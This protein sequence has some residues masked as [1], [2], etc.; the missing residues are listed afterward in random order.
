MNSWKLVRLNFGSNAAHFGELGIGIEETSERVRSDTLF[1]ALITAYAQL[2]PDAVSNLLQ[3]FLE[4][5]NKPPFR[6]SSTFLYQQVAD[7]IVDYLPKPLK[8]PCNY[9]Q[10]DDLAF[11]KT[12]KK[13]NFLPVEVWHRWYQE[14]G[15]RALGVDCDCHQLIQETTNKSNGSLRKACTFSY[16]KGFEKTLL[17]KIAVDR[18]TKATNLYHTGLIHFKQQSGLYFIIQFPEV[19][20]KLE[21]QV[22]AALTLLGEQG[23]GGERSSGSGQFTFQWF[24]FSQLSETWQKVLN[25]PSLTHYS[26]I[27]LFW[28]SNISESLIEGSSYELQKR[29]GWIYSS[30]GYQLRR[31][32]V[33]MFAEG[34]VFQTQPVGQLADVT[35]E[36]FNKYRN[37]HPIYRSGISLSLPIK[38]PSNI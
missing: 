8:F 29:G 26:L 36:N 15:F 37:W 7:K 12:Y 24:E 22:K 13:L 35:P 38:L 27:S 30:S 1:S 31:K 10:D 18:I 33:Q 9:P 28:E 17:P 20:N 23:L 32:S 21:T 14:D 25:S 5:P 3:Q 11:F 19:N 4:Q 6:L 16:G 2:F 34:S